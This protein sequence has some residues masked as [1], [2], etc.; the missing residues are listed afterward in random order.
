MER[1]LQGIRLKPG[2]PQTRLLGSSG[3]GNWGQNPV[4]HV[5][6]NQGLG[7]GHIAGGMGRA[8]PL[9]RSYEGV[10]RVPFGR[11][12]NPTVPFPGDSRA[13]AR[14]VWAKGA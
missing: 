8:F 9:S 4:R 2:R 6:L 13:G 3:R 12:H 14:G 11:R 5:P 10:L 7:Q 1:R